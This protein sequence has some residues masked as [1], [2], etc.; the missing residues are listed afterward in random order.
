MVQPDSATAYRNA[1]FSPNRARASLPDE[2]FP[3]K[4]WTEEMRS[5]AIS[6]YVDGA[7]DREIAGEMTTKFGCTVTPSSGRN[8]MNRCSPH[9]RD[10]KRAAH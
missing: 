1:R 2:E 9:R 3:M 10:E 4:K 5:Y 7:N 8:M 6:R